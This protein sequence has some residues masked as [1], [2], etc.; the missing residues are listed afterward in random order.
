MV[1]AC[2]VF[3]PFFVFD[4][5]FTIIVRP[6][7]LR[8]PLTYVQHAENTNARAQCIEINIPKRDGHT[9]IPTQNEMRSRI[10]CLALRRSATKTI[11]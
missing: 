4:A 10:S 8:T 2:M 6:H 3:L 5:T 7:P 9:Y 1:S 11:H